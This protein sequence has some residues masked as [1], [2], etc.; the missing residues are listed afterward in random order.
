M[1]PVTDTVD[2]PAEPIDHPSA[3]LEEHAEVLIVQKDELAVV[4]ARDQVETGDRS[5]RDVPGVR[6]R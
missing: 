4:A 6:T 5:T 3:Q 1:P 2:D